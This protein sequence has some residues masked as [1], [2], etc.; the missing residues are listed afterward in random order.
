MTMMANSVP[1]ACQFCPTRC[2][3]AL[4]VVMHEQTDHMDAYV[5]FTTYGREM[6]T[7]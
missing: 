2:A 1:L 4:D 3:T 6:A 5:L 7:S